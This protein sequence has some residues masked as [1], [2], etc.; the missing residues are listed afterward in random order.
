MMG[1]A[2]P[3][4]LCYFACLAHLSLLFLGVLFVLYIF[5]TFTDCV[6]HIS[7]VLLL[8]Y[9]FWVLI[10]LY[11]L[12]LDSCIHFYVE[13]EIR[14]KDRILTFFFDFVRASV[15][16]LYVTAFGEHL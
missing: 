2:L 3:F 16:L 8:P 1:V 7:Y 4:D 10:V 14:I 9:F 15:I 11:F 12:L 5:F 13:R 6:A